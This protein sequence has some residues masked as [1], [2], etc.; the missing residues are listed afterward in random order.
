MAPRH[1]NAIA[2]QGGACN[3]VALSRALVAAI[4]EVR[5]ETQS[6]DA[7]RG[8]AAVRLICHQLSYLLDIDGFD[9]LTKFAA[10]MKE[11]EEAP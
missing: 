2:A 1:R 5:A 3:P 6:T 9:N 10:A 7:I 8:D 4:D 11:C